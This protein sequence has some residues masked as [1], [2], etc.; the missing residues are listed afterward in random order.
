M[1]NSLR[2]II[3]WNIKLTIFCGILKHFVMT[4]KELEMQVLMNKRRRIRT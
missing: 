4:T 1:W 2:D 3:E